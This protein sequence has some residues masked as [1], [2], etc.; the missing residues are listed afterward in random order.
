MFEAR[1]SLGSMWMRIGCS[2]VRFRWSPA[3]LVGFGDGGEPPA[4]V[5]GSADGSG[6]DSKFGSVYV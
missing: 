3:V 5:V 4:A 1:F 6:G 2:C